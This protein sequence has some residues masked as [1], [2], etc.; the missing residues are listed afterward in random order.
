[1]DW[2]RNSKKLLDSNGYLAEKMN[3]NYAY[4]FIVNNKTRVDVKYSKLYKGSS[5]NFYAFNLE[6]KFHDCDVYILIC[7]EDK[8]N[9]KTIIIPQSFVHN[10]G[11]ISVGET[12]SK[13]YKYIDRFD[14][15]DIFDKL[16][17]ELEYLK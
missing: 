12:K 16:Y 6:Q 4:D 10:Q 8:E 3:T 13:W 5:G 7:E 14:F 11:Q 9:L 1:M 2:R 17:K 15:I